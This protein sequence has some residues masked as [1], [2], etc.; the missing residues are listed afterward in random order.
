MD[1]SKE[2]FTHYFYDSTHPEKLSRPPFYKEN[3]FDHI[4][5]IKEDI[6]GAIWIGTLGQGI[7]RYDPGT[8]KITHYGI[9][10]RGNKIVSTKDT[11]AGYKD[12]WTWSAF[13]SKDGLFWISTMEG[14]LYQVNPL[15][16]EIP[17]YK[18]DRGNSFYKEPGNNILWIATEKGLV[19]KDLVSGTEKVWR[20]DPYNNNSLCN[21]IIAVV[22]TDDEGNLWIPTVNGQVN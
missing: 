10:R 20:H 5:F 6:T 15:K 1:R 18:S 8:K 4:T 17:Y 9:I 16:I 12:F 11:A 14:N 3:W 19:R 7:N 22:R 13:T 2:T 21:D